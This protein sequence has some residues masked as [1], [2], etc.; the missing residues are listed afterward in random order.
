MADPLENRPQIKPYNRTTIS[1]VIPYKSGFVYVFPTKDKKWG[2][3]GGKIEVFEPTSDAFSREIAEETGLE[4]VLQKDSLLG[5]WDFRS[6]QGN[7]VT[8]KVFYCKVVGGK[9]GLT[10]P[11]EISQIET[12]N[13]KRIRELYRSGKI[14]AGRA[15]LEPVE[16]YIA[17]ERYPISLI[18]TLF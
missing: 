1:A 11:Q 15:N 6:E 14:R 12:F 13:L 3:P 7:C 10:R 4:V 9:L 18:H 2:L 16:R 8:N 5:I 17:G